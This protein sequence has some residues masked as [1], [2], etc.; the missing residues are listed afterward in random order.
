[1]TTEQKVARRNLSL[2]ELI[3]ASSQGPSLGA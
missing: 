2:P 3:G 1:M